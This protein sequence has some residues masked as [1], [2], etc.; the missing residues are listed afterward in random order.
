MS[1]KLYNLLLKLYPNHFRRAYGDAALRLVLD[2]ARDE[3]GFL[4][5]L[6]LWLDLLVDL[7]IS[8]PR[9]YSKAPRT[10]ILAANPANGNPSFQLLT[11]R[12]LNPALLLVAGL[13]TAALFWTCVTA[14]A[15]SRTFPARFP[16]DSY[17]LQAIVQSDVA[18]ARSA[19]EAE[20]GINNRDRNAESGSVGLYSFCITAHRDMPRN[21][22]QPLLRFS[23]ASPGASGAALI[24]GKIVKT[25]KNEQHLWI[26][27]DMS[28]G[29]HA[30]VLRVDR[31]A[32][33]A[34]I[35]SNKDFG[36]CPAK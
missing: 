31:R 2:R 23:F 17:S 14:A 25:F 5:G 7:A 32:E 16:A 1:E 13:L 26:S 33:N 11:G 21:S 29:N 9:E 18:L 36:Y 15:H 22:L 20:S 28:A 27:A 30:F 12:S 3:K 35:S 8:L 10:R 24:D 19:S 34:S 6:R 4:C